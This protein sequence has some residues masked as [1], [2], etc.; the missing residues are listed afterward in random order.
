MKKAKKKVSQQLK[1]KQGNRDQLIVLPPNIGEV[2]PHW[3]PV[4]FVGQLVG[5]MDI[6]DILAT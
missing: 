1:F 3:H 2:L 6:S 4:R 5:L